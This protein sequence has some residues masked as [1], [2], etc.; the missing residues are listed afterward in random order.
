M[1][2]LFG[3]FVINSLLLPLHAH[4]LDNHGAVTVQPLLQT[5]SSWD[6]TPLRWPQGEAE[7]TGL[8][9]T[10]AP[11]GETGWHSHPVPSF[12]LLLE[13]ELEITLRSGAVKRLRAGEAL[14]EVVGVA[15]NGRV[16]GDVP[17]RLVV[18]YAGAKGVPLTVR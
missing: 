8:I 7:L 15:H 9:V 11:G 18:F 6:G 14:A 4:A 3:F 10:I 12:G 13:G 1:R 5:T 2:L 16:I 17:A